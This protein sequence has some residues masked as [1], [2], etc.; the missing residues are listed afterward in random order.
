MG[1]GGDLIWTCVFRELKRN[2]Q[3]GI[4]VETPMLSDILAGCL[5]R[6]DRDFTANAIFNLNP[7]IGH[8]TAKPKSWPVRVFDYLFQKLI[9]F[10][11]I[12]RHYE[13]AI[14]QA[15][16][17]Q[18]T[19]SLGMDKQHILVHLDMRIHSYALQKKGRKIIWKEQPFAAAAVAEHF[20]ISIAEP[21][22]FLVFSDDE[23][24]TVDRML[25]DAGVAQNF[26][27]FDP[28]T[29]EDWFGLLR[30]WSPEN[31]RELVTRAKRDFPGYQFVQIGLAKTGVVDGA[32]NLTSKTSFRQAAMVIARSSLFLGTESGLM[33]AAAAVDARSI[34]LWGGVTRPEFAGYPDKHE[35]ICRYVTC[36][37]CGNL[38][39]CDFNHK[40][41]R[42]ITVDDVLDRVRSMIG[43]A[44]SQAGRDNS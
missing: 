16:Q 17:R 15:S 1:Y 41:M 13:Q 22:C 36:S 44:P 42:Q 14:F 25:V 21:S 6:R 40:C 10:D 37:P 32:V 34:I 29:N 23:W 8:V 39:H 26:I 9:T 3:Q 27:V 20:N 38:G 30:A 28:D 19:Q 35:I 7:D 18:R 31:W 24:V 33:H 12:R 11:P 5:F 4:A 43:T 2:G